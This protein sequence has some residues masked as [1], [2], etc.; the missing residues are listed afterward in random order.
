MATDTE[1]N[2]ELVSVLKSV[3]NVLE[4]GQKAMAE[5]GEHLKVSR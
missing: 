4:D 3:I 5:I 2:S 1:Q